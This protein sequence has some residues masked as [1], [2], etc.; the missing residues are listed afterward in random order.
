ALAIILLVG[1]GLL[2]RTL[3]RLG[4]STLGFDP[5]RILTLHISAGW[6]EK[7]DTRQVERRLYRTLEAV[8]AISGVEDAALT[9]SLPG[10][11]ED[12]PGEFSIEGHA[13]GPK[14]FADLQSVSPEFFRVLRIPMLAGET[15]RFSPDE[16]LPD[17][18]L[19]NRAFA[20]QFFAGENP[21]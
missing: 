5:D 7:N 6:G 11:G 2:I 15:C 20:D 17:T 12:Y 10:T 18:V 4:Q 9:V 14:T 19:V 21:I 13:P 16:K 1:A 3:G 8:R